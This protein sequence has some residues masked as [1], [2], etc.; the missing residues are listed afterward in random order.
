MNYFIKIR[1]QEFSSNSIDIRY[2]G[3][4]LMQ[5]KNILLELAFFINL[6]FNMYQTLIHAYYLTEGDI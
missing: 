1:F 6:Y 4:H 3:T 2:L 5:D